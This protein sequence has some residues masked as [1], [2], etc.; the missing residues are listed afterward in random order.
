MET[1]NLYNFEAKFKELLTAEKIASITIRNYL[2]DLRFFRGWAI[3]EHKNESVE[4][5]FKAKSLIDFKSYLLQSGLPYKTIN[6]RLSTLR[7]ICKLLRKEHVIESYPETELRNVPISNQGTSFDPV[8][9]EF[10]QELFVKDN[11][12]PQIDEQIKDIKD[13]FISLNQI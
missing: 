12:N 2:S 9:E 6:R 4:A 5:I 1:Y 3:Q 7:K 11:D 8:I 10:R 13:L